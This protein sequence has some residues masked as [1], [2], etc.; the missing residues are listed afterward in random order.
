VVTQMTEIPERFLTA[1]LPD[2]DIEI[3][4]DDVPVVGLFMALKTQWL[5]HPFTGQ[6]MGI[7][8]A[9]VKP[10]AEL[11]EIDLPRGILPKLQAMEGAALETF[12][13]ASK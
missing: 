8:Y 1:P 11:A 4:P 3:H 2:D 12:A 13:A 5:R 10:T 9:A 6:R 7:D